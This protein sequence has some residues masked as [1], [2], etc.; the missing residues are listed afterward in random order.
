[1]NHVHQTRSRID[2]SATNPRSSRRRIRDQNWSKISSG[3]FQACWYLPRQSTNSYGPRKSWRGSVL[4]CLL[5]QPRPDVKSRS[6]STTQHFKRVADEAYQKTMTSDNF[7]AALAPSF[8]GGGVDSGAG[9]TRPLADL[10]PSQTSRKKCTTLLGN[11]AHLLPQT[12]SSRKPRRDAAE[13]VSSGSVVVAER[14]KKKILQTVC[15][16][17]LFKLK[18]STN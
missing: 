8:R 7:A 10:T 12:K 17:P 18:E 4:V 1:M 2:I 6:I 15:D 9:P 16:D 14:P 3:N 11:L 13:Q 5:H